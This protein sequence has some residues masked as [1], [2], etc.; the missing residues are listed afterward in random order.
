M[1]IYLSD[2]LKRVTFVFES[3]KFEIIDCDY[4]CILSLNPIIDK[5]FRFFYI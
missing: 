5:R 2:S 4:L 3:N 1:Q